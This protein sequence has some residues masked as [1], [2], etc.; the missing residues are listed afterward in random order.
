[1]SKASV[2]REVDCLEGG[3]GSAA[4]VDSG[5]RDKGAGIVKVTHNTHL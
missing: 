3:F 1:M 2:G 4:I 5:H